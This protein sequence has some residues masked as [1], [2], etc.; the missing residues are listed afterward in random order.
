MFLLIYM[1]AH[2]DQVLKGHIYWPSMT[3]VRWQ[4]RKCLSHAPLEPQHHG[5]HPQTDVPLWEL[6]M[7]GRRLRSLQ[8][9]LR[10]RRAIL[11][12]WV[13]VQLADV[14]TVAVRPRSSPIPWRLGCSPAWPSSCHQHHRASNPGGVTSTPG[15][16]PANLGPTVD[17]ETSL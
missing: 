15:N 13:Y 11:R 3:S 10:L 8:W 16:R 1:Y 7:S 5:S 9:S 6:C 12:R 17:L 2:M 14:P 4:N